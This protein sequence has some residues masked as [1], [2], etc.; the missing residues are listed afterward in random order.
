MAFSPLSLQQIE[1]LTDSQVKPQYEATKGHLSTLQSKVW[2]SE[3][4]SKPLQDEL[5][6]TIRQYVWLRARK[7]PDYFED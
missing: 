4:I 3:K 1:N 2:Y 6:A 7:F 5:H